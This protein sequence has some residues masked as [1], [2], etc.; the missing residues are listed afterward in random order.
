MSQAPD[1]IERGKGDPS[2]SLKRWPLLRGEKPLLRGEMATL[3]YGGKNY[4]FGG[5]LEAPFGK[6]NGVGHGKCP[7]CN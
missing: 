4:N 1:I 6:Q 3:D 7:V 2:L 5:I